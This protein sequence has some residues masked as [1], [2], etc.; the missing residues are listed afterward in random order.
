MLEGAVECELVDA[1]LG[2]SSVGETNGARGPG[3][4]LHD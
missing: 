3:N 1:E 4:F 2:V